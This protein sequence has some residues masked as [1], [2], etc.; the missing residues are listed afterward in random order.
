MNKQALTELEFL[1]EKIKD[2]KQKVYSKGIVLL[3]GITTI[4]C[5]ALATD[6]FGAII[7]S[8]IAISGLVF[9]AESLRPIKT[10]HNNQELS[11]EKVPVKKNIITHKNK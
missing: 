11:M 6:R 8:L 4:T 7:G 9:T 2:E 5:G 3:P 10:A 1:N